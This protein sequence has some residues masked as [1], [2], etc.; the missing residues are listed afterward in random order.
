MDPKLIKYLFKENHLLK[1]DYY[2]FS[3]KKT[4]INLKIKYKVFNPN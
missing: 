2:I 4:I 1:K 3:H